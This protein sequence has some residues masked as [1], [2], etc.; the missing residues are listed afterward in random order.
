M[1]RYAGSRACALRRSVVDS[2]IRRARTTIR[3]E[4]IAICDGL[5]RPDGRRL[6]S[7]RQ[8]SKQWKTGSCNGR[9]SE[10]P[11]F[12][13][14]PAA[15]FVEPGKQSFAIK[16]R[17][18]KIIAAKPNANDFSLENALQVRLSLLERYWIRAGLDNFGRDLAFQY[19]H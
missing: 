9:L 2:W 17:E 14:R 15:Y 11:E 13:N 3:Q 19:L 18:R 5:C 6:Q 12:S 10:L 7:A 16:I 4:R 1:C 8:S